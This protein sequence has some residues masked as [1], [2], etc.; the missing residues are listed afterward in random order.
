MM[1]LVRMD[2]PFSWFVG[3]KR[4][5]FNARTWPD[6]CII[7]VSRSPCGTAAAL[8]SFLL[9]HFKWKGGSLSV[10][11]G[12]RVIVKRNNLQFPIDCRRPSRARMLAHYKAIAQAEREK[13]GGRE[14]GREARHPCPALS[15]TSNMY[16]ALCIQSAMKME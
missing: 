2:V 8:S 3:K 13:E 12:S 7:G 5:N 1:L 11:I 10:S 14:G 6:A 15:H 4:L 9:I 16:S